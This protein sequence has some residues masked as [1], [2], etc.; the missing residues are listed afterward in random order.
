VL[1]FFCASVLFGLVFNIVG[2]SIKPILPCQLGD[3]DISRSCYSRNPTLLPCK[4][5][6]EKR[7]TLCTASLPIALIFIPTANIFLPLRFKM[8]TAVIGEKSA[9]L[10]KRSRC[11]WVS[12]RGGISSTYAPQV[13][14]DPTRLI[15]DPRTPVRFQ[16]P[17]SRSDLLRNARAGSEFPPTPATGRTVSCSNR[18]LLVLNPL[19]TS[20]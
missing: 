7:T 14:P 2:S 16:R 10:A 12:L 20:S 3:I 13:R 8:F 6:Q 17:E 4:A 19:L 5:V 9:G 15:N 18:L 1:T 11:G